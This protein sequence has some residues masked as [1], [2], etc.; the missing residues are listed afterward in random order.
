MGYFSLVMQANTITRSKLIEAIENRR[1]AEAIRIFAETDARLLKTGN[2]HA[3]A[4]K[5]TVASVLLG[6]RYEENIAKMGVDFVP[7]SRAWGEKRKSG[8]IVDH[9]GKVYLIIRST[10]KSRKANKKFVEFVD[11]GEKIDFETIRPF[12]PINKGSAK[13]AALGIE[14]SRQVE[15]RDFSIENILAVKMRGEFFTVIPD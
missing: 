11:N 7:S 8:K 15:E 1:G 4:R 9:K 2:P 5:R 10:E 13:Q 14:K 12:F 6:T 3:S